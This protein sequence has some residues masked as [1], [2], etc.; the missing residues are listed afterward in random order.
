MIQSGG[1]YFATA[2]ESALFW[3]GHKECNISGILLEEMRGFVVEV[4]IEL[5]EFYCIRPDQ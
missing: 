5:T 3:S 2:R 4:L 1:I